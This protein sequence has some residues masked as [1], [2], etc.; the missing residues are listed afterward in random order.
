MQGEV[1][2][3]ILEL[4]VA[5]ALGFLYAEALATVLL[6]LGVGTLEEEY[7]AIALVGK[8]VG[9][10]TV[11]EPTVVTDYH[12]TASKGL[13]TFLQGT[14]GVDVNIVGG[15]VEQEHIAFLLQCHGQVQTV[16]LTAGEHAA[17]LLLVG[18]GEVEA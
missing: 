6:V 14:E 18:T 13:E 4:A 3:L 2:G 11:Q 12:S 17:L 9:A 10:D 7:L 8:D 15:L 16:A 1:S 5:D